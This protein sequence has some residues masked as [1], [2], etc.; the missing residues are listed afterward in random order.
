MTPAQYPHC[1]D[2][3]LLAQAERGVLFVDR[4]KLQAYLRRRHKWAEFLR[5]TL[6]RNVG[7]SKGY[8]PSEI[9]KFLAK[10]WETNSQPF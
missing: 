6:N 5:W 2:A 3:G 10:I 8:Q 4:D 1:S 9:E 7:T